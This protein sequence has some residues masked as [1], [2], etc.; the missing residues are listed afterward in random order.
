MRHLLLLLLF[1]TTLPAAAQTTRRVP[2]AG[3]VYRTFTVEPYQVQ[4]RSAN[5][6]LQ[7][8]LRQGP[9]WEGRRYF[10]LTTSRMRYEYLMRTVATGCDLYDIKVFVDV[11]MTLPRWRPPTGTPYALERSW[12]QFE[13]NLRFHEEGHKRLIEEEA[14]IIR[15]TLDAVR[16]PGCD[17]VGRVAQMQIE[18]VRGA[19][20]ELH[21]SYDART[22]HGRTQGALWP[23]GE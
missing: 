22:Q 7:A 8:M 2:D 11:T 23:L 13:R 19:Y 3:V 12:R 1:A 18:Q 20:A 16:T 15:R 9:N 21:H 4:G 17:T 10:G 14:E 6:L 5:D